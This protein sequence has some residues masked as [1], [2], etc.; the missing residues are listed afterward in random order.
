MHTSACTPALP[1]LSTTT[2]NNNN[3]HN[4]PPPPQPPTSPTH[5]PTHPHRY[6]RENHNSVLGIREY[7]LQGGGAFQA[8]NES[9]VEAWLASDAPD[10]AAGAEG[11]LGSGGSMDSASAGG[12]GGSCEQDQLAYSLF[13][14]PAEDNFAGVKYP[15]G[16]VQRVR[17]KS[18]EHHRWAGAVWGVGRCRW[19][20]GRGRRSAAGAR[21]AALGA[22]A[23]PTPWTRS[24]L[25][26]TT[27]HPLARPPARQVEGDG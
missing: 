7:A 19:R 16:W 27:N 13:A 2:N 4:Q 17:D 5:P 11:V 8:V 25:P 6:L 18:S 22:C 15:L 10:L 14:F 20:A 12:A 1:L 23:W 24:A 3:H 21:G 9:F 26:P